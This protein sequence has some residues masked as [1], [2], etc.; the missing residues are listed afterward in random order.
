MKVLLIRPRDGVQINTR[1]PESVNKVQ[2]VYP[3]LGLAYVA[4]SLEEEGHRVSIIDAQAEGLSRED[5]K[6]RAVLERPDAI[7]ASSMTST[8][9]GLI[10][11]MRACK[12]A[13]P[14]VP[15]IIGGPHMDTYPVETMSHREIDFGIIGEGEP[16]FP[17]LLNALSGKRRFSSVNSIIYKKRSGGAKR[18]K[19]YSIVRDLDS[20]PFPARHLLPNDKYGSILVDKPFTTMISS[21]GCPYRCGYCFKAPKDR[22]M[23]F[24]SP[25]KIAD[26]IEECLEKYRTRDLWFYDDTLTLSK[27]HINGICNE[28]I[29]RKLSVRWEGVTRVDRINPET[30]RIMRKSGCRRMRL[31]IESGSNRILKRMIKDITVER[32][33]E[34]VSTLRKAGIETFGFFMLGY[35]GDTEK[36]MRETID[37]SKSSGVDWAMFSV[38]TPYPGTRLHEEAVRLGAIRKDYWRDFVLGTEKGRIPFFMDGLE[39]VSKRAYSEFYFRPEFVIGRLSSIKSVSDIFRYLKGFYALA[40]YRMLPEENVFS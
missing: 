34:T 13:L 21:R 38:T 35:P 22:A 33:R 6:R 7:G 25:K 18:T 36:T 4:A 28:I 1:L 19:G 20:L 10:E 30:A 26:E 40:K 24:R 32:A 16:V 23:R 31:G 15:T 5:L 17:R 37:F 12:E 14:D 27:S 29:G 2:G 3:P 11:A 9:W 8:F 39:G